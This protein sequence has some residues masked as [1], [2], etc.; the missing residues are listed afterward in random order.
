MGLSSWAHSWV[1]LRPHP[2][3]YALLSLFF[4]A[5]QWDNLFLGYM[6][7]LGTPGV[8]GGGKLK[9]IAYANIIQ[10]IQARTVLGFVP[11]FAS[12]TH[13]S[14]DRTEPQIGAYVVQQVFSKWRDAWLVELL[15]PAL[16][17]WNDWV[18]EHRRGEGVFAGADGHADLIVLG[19]DPTDPPC[20]VGG[21]N[22]MQAARYESGLDNSPMY[23]LEGA[24]FAGYRDFDNETTHHMAL[25]DV[26]MTALYLSDTEALIGLATV[27]GRPDA[28]AGL[29]VR[30]ARVQTAMNAH[31][32][33]AEAGMYSNVLFNGTFYRRWSPT[34]F[35]PLISGS[36][37]DAQA[38]AL[39]ASLASP[40]GFCF[41]DSH[42]PAGDAS[43]VATWWDGAHDNAQCLSDE[44]TRV[45]VDTRYDFVRTEAV[46]HGAGAG[47]APGLVPLATWYSA[48]RGDTAMTNSTTA[49]PDADGEYAFVRIEGW[50]Y[51]A[52]P[53][54]GA[55][56]AVNLSL[57]FSDARKD[58]KV[59]GSDSA[60]TTTHKNCFSDAG[61][62]IVGVIGW[63][64]SSQG[65]QNLPCRFGG[66]SI[67]RGDANFYDNDYWRG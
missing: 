12:G 18:W 47:P 4:R 51:A 48:A 2:L 39:A 52:P 26:G 43:V 49:P 29:Q 25:Y 17:S 30:F 42:K 62:A 24:A 34:S 45:Q 20:D 3:P 37:S 53:P 66:N 1:H 6:A 19:S 8:A 60:D 41:N 64:W 16:L 23:D 11:N 57:W 32:W 14:F 36:A 21:F 10:I 15:F 33:D 7:S 5:M 35:F 44:C 40:T 22:N 59:C 65:P 28:V 13:I 54:P 38:T 27:A 31:M 50:A 67:A 9:D 55:W 58:Y 63:A 56:P 46:A 61:Y